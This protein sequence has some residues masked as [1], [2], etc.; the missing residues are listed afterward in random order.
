[1][2]LG[3]SGGKMDPYPRHILSMKYLRT[4]QMTF[5]GRIRKNVLK[6]E[7]VQVPA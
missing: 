3:A 2:A 6:T 7:N 1:M 4:V 5:Y